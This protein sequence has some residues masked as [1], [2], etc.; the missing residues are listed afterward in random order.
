MRWMSDLSEQVAESEEGCSL[1]SLSVL[2]DAQRND[3][4]VKQDMALNVVIA[5][6]NLPTNPRNH[7]LEIQSTLL[8]REWHVASSLCPRGQYVAS[9]ILT[10]AAIESL[11]RVACQSETDVGAK[12]WF[13][14]EKV[15]FTDLL[16]DADTSGELLAR[17]RE[18]SEIAHSKTA[19]GIAVVGS[20]IL[21]LGAQFDGPIF[22]KLTG[23]LD[24]VVAQFL[25][26]A[27]ESLAGS[28]QLDRDTRRLLGQ[29]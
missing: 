17:R 15:C 21:L 8:L 29:L 23:V 24:F 18:L 7:F 16:R 13:D 11:A 19:A 3:L 22:R 2:S 27:R 5:M 20:G 1:T 14:D 4:N 28:L 6:T 10:R 12:A 25:R 26:F 9:A